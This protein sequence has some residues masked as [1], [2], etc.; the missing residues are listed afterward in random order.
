MQLK[1]DA[2]PQL[3]F[4]RSDA[5]PDVLGSLVELRKV[6]GLLEKLRS[7]L[8]S[9]YA[10]DGKFAD[11]GIRVLEKL[12]N[13]PFRVGDG[14]E[15]GNSQESNGEG[16]I[17]LTLQQWSFIFG[18]LSGAE[19]SISLDSLVAL[20][21]SS[22]G[23]TDLSLFNPFITKT[24]A[25]DVFS[26][27]AAILFVVN[28][29][30]QLCRALHDVVAL[31][32]FLRGR[33]LESLSPSTTSD[34]ADLTISRKELVRLELLVTSLA[35]TLDTARHYVDL[36]ESSSVCAVYDPRFLAFEFAYSIILREEQ[37]SLINTFVASV[38]QKRSLC[39]Q[40]VMGAGK[41]TVRCVVICCNLLRLLKFFIILV[42][43]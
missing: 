2:I 28:R 31:E 23:D 35:T 18:K 41:T 10:R 8:T 33:L 14:T 37:I 21:I 17:C 6:V 36:Q 30:A 43:A 15:G 24:V 5:L 9:A 16:S 3:S 42:R 13:F 29:R 22:A 7:A 1:S 40:A 4:L 26:L 38:M 12:A 11:V 39:H 19:P 27:T 20:L 25:R 34:V 32:T